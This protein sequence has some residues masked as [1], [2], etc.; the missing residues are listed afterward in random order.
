MPI[1]MRSIVLPS[2][3]N[4]VSN[5]TLKVLSSGRGGECDARRLC[6]AREE[7]VKPTSRYVLHPESAM[8]VWAGSHVAPHFQSPTSLLSI[9][10]ILSKIFSSTGTDNSIWV[11][12]GTR[13]FDNSPASNPSLPAISPALF[14][15][16][17]ALA[18][19]SA[20]L[21]SIPGSGLPKRSL[22]VS[23]ITATISHRLAR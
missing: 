16:A 7:D 17:V 23:L 22:H 6:P 19:R 2:S 10:S 21:T 9:A 14:P 4:S 11:S 5:H 20:N 1:E 12:I 18:S 8:P 3:M 13:I 15:R